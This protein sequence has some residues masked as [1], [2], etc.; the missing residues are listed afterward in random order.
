[1]AYAPPTSSARV[2]FEHFWIAANRGVDVTSNEGKKEKKSNGTT[3]V[4]QAWW[5]EKRGEKSNARKMSQTKTEA[6]G[7]ILSA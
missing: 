2:S 6:I 3:S 4:C 5:T 7:H 1:L